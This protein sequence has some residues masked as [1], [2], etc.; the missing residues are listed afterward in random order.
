MDIGNLHIDKKYIDYIIYAVLGIVFI[1]A[2]SLIFSSDK[3]EK[4][5]VNPTSSEELVLDT[6]TITVKVGEE[7]QISAHVNNNDNA[8]ITYL[9]I[10]T[11]IATIN[12]NTVRGI[13]IGRTY[14]M[15]T[16]RDNNGTD[17]I[18]H[19]AVDVLTNENFWVWLELTICC[20]ACRQAM[21]IKSK[22][23]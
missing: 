7:A 5:I 20:E 10:N 6:P 1:Y 9:S 2:L 15:V 3:E 18:K 23:T 8:A 16:Y 19:C 12:G 14:I 17:Q 4:T 21:P 22:S 11:D 13:N